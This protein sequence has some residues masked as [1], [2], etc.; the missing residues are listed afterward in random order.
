MLR[1]GQSDSYLLLLILVVSVVPVDL[2][3][4]VPVGVLEGHVGLPLYL[5]L[6]DRPVQVL[7]HEM[8]LGGLL[9]DAVGAGG[10]ADQVHL[11][12]YLVH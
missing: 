2:S 6:V 7:V 4:V 11:E 10:H 8:V 3:G 12:I 5:L 9:A 1:Y